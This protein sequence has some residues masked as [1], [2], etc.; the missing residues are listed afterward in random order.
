MS[1]IFTCFFCEVPLVCPADKQIYTCSCGMFRVIR[2]GNNDRFI[3]TLPKEVMDA[4]NIANYTRIK[5][6]L[7]E[8]KFV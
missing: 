8:R 6:E 3:S 2:S 7:T 5:E 4:Q 1:K